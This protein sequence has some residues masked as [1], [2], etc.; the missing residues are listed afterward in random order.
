MIDKDLISEPNAYPCVVTLG[1]QLRGNSPANP[2]SISYS[3][4]TVRA[5]YIIGADGANSWT[6]K[7]LQFTTEKVRTSFIWG[8]IDMRVLSDFPE[9]VAP[10]QLS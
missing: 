10:F 5:K 8:V 6:R 4:E 7:Q 1:R 9:Y 2:T 3:E